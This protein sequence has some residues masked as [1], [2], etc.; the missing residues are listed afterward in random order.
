M[1]RSL[2]LLTGGEGDFFRFFPLF[3]SSD[4]LQCQRVRGARFHVL[5]V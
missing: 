2:L 4:R 5:Q 1:E 3:F